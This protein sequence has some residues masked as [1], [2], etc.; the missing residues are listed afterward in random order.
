M[1]AELIG[2][3]VLDYPWM[4]C[5]GPIGDFYIGDGEMYNYTRDACRCIAILSINTSSSDEK[6]DF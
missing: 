4:L 1:F 2:Y 5:L 6:T 3:L